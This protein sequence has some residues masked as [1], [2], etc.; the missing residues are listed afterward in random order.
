MEGTGCCDLP[1]RGHDDGVDGGGGGGDDV[2]EEPDLDLEIKPA[3]ARPLIRQIPAVVVAIGQTKHSGDTTA[4]VNRIQTADSQAGFYGW[5]SSPVLR[6]MHHT[7]LLALPRWQFASG[8]KQ[9]SYKSAFVALSS[10][11]ERLLSQS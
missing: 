3:L 10:F 9:C 5:H 4:S 2:G 7:G 6:S 8:R 11:A 1:D